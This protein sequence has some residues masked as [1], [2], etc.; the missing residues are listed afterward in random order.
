VPTSFSVNVS[1]VF[2]DHARELFEHSCHTIAR[3]GSLETAFEKALRHLQAEKTIDDKVSTDQ[4]IQ[5]YEKGRLVAMATFDNGEA[6]WLR[7]P[8][9]GDVMQWSQDVT[10]NLSRIEDEGLNANVGHGEQPFAFKVCVNLI[11][12]AKDKI[13]SICH[14]RSTDEVYAT[15][16]RVEARMMNMSATT[17]LPSFEMT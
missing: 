5:V 15:L 14:P 1:T 4:S 9:L 10:Q 7:S 6:V 11:A 17:A 16:R 2:V 13:A 8:T 3:V 12:M